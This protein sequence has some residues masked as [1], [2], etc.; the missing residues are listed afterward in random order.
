MHLSLKTSTSL[1]EGDA[2][3]NPDIVVMSFTD[4]DLASV[5]QAYRGAS[6]DA[7]SLCLT[8]M[9]PLKHPLSIDLYLEQ[10]A[11]HAKVI[12]VR[13][14]GGQEWWPYGCEEL[15]RLARE[16]NIALIMVPG[17]GHPD[18]RLSELSTVSKELTG[19]ID[20][21]LSNGGIENTQVV[22]HAL[23]ELASG[24]PAS[25]P[26]A[27]SVANGALYKKTKPLSAAS[28]TATIIFY[29]AHYLSSD[30]EPVDALMQALTSEGLAVRAFMVKSLKDAEA[31]HLLKAD[32]SHYK[33]DIL[34]DFTAFSA[35]DKVHPLSEV[36]VPIL[37]CAL[38]NA[39]AEAWENSARGLSTTDL[40][41]HVVLPE[42]DGRIFT[43]AISFKNE[44]G[45]DDTMQFKHVVHQVQPDRVAYVAK[46]AANWGRL[47][48]KQKS[49][50]KVVLMVSN[51][52][53]RAGRNAYAVGLDGPASVIN[54]LR[55]LKADGYATHTLDML[56]FSTFPH[57]TYSLEAYTRRFNALPV[58]NRQA[59]IDAWGTPQQDPAFYNGAFHV[60]CLCLDNV[61]VALQ[62]DRGS[63]TDKKSGYHDA[64]MPPRHGYLAFYW[65]LQDVAAIDALIH[66]G[67]HGNLEWLPGKSVALSSRCWPE[68]A[69]G[70]TPV[71]YPYI[72][73][74]PGES[75]Q[76]K[77]RISAVVLSHLTPPLMPVS[78]SDELAELETLVDEFSAADGLD[79]RRM[80]LL[81]TEILHRARRTGIAGEDDN[82]LMTALESHLCDIKEQ[83]V[84]DGLHVF[85]QAAQA[86][87]METMAAALHEVSNGEHDKNAIIQL[88]NQSVANEA[89]GLLDALDGK[90]IMAGAG[91]SPVRGRFD[92]MPTGR[93][94]ISIDPRMIPTPTAALIGRRAAEEF[95]RRYSQDHGDWPKSVMMDVWG[96]S[97]LR[98]GGDEIAQALW[99]MGVNPLWDKASGRVNGFEV[100]ADTD[101]SWP[102]IDVTLRV[103][104]LFRDMFAN[105][106][107]LFDD[108]VQ[109][110][111]HGNKHTI[112]VFS[113]AEGVYGSGVNDVLAAGQWKD[114]GELGKAYMAASHF[115]YGRDME[116]VAS[117]ELFKER[118]EAADALIHVQDTREMDVLNGADFVD[119]EGGFSAAAQQLGNDAALY[120]VD[121]SRPDNIKART[122]AEEISLTLHSRALNAKWIE[123]QMRHGYAGAGAFADVADQLFFFAA[124]TQCVPSAQFDQV[125]DAYL[126]DDHVRNFMEKENPEAL[127]SIKDRLAEALRRGFW[128][129]LR[130][131]VWPML[132]LDEADTIK[133]QAA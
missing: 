9:G 81:R 123:G 94:L 74:D 19:A 28:G 82:D 98:N 7:P 16:K 23:M 72:V 114:R 24:K 29:R 34:I 108:A 13:L 70:A 78:L 102:R 55:L 51:Y 38:A 14:L 26:V 2:P 71:I 104:G 30:V 127:Q 92:I 37:Q 46:L 64:K 69:M 53:D 62:P 65:W 27:A 96:A 5:A 100:L 128:N 77:R 79:A 97:T 63:A 115:A 25:V 10:V 90:F 50:R 103:S 73:S 129:P 59:L 22:L 109:K 47:A 86:Q 43:R 20:E 80:A 58:E 89:Q 1:D 119:V 116:G 4:S 124:T 31:L 39:S 76:A 44:V 113:N 126:Y 45:N 87:S 125:F 54:I 12:L 83:R 42:A 21:C 131:S 85:A 17:C 107:M 60:P 61:I 68:I 11:A 84:G 106:I 32:V 18:E 93:N 120:H 56:D 118:V 91:G 15:G 8:S 130:N 35:G 57:S 99:L 40:A 95:V 52:P 49:G 36:G 101:M 66:I 110:V 6:G 33:P 67:T 133:G 88:L 117:P 105:I 112:R 3:V 122:L 48:K 132:G 121:T 41:M 111:H 75:A